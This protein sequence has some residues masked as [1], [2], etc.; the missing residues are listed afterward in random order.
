[1]NKSLWFLWLVPLFLGG[2]IFNNSEDKLEEKKNK[3][4]ILSGNLVVSVDESLLD[5]VEEQKDMF[6]LSYYNA[7]VQLLSNPE[8]FAIQDLLNGASYTA[9]LTRELS[10][11]ENGYFEKRHIKP[12]VFK[13]ATDA[14]ILLTSSSVQDTTITLDAIKS[15]LNGKDAGG[16]KEIAFPSLE[17]S[18]FRELLE[19]SDLDKAVNRY[20]TTYGSSKEVL[21]HLLNSS[22]PVLGAIGYSEYLR[23]KK[24]FDEIN[25]IRILSVLNN[26]GEFADGKYHQPTQSNL[27]LG[28]Y[29]LSRS[30]YVLN[31]QPNI[32]LGIGWSAFLT[33]DR[34]QRIVLKKGILPAKMPGREIIIRE[35]IN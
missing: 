2:C 26:E 33:G 14:I 5:F 3:E 7:K 31:Y 1:M 22:E 17:S 28:V 32:G 19:K 8:R 30:V 35:A 20:V 4:D 13:V 9:V 18:V 6:E 24:T 10:A 16:Y 27:A 29:P 25:K 15:L 11:E 21:T 12:R 23:Y 34:G